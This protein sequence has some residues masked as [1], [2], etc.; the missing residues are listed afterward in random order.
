MCMNVQ[1]L[2]LNMDTC[3]VVVCLLSVYTN[4]QVLQL[5]ERLELGKFSHLVLTKKQLSKIRAW[6]NSSIYGDTRAEG[7]STYSGTNSEETSADCSCIGGVL[8]KWA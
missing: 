5:L 3:R 1:V 7:V 6:E 2:Y 8:A 4:F